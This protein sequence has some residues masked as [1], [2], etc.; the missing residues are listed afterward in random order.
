MLRTRPAGP[1]TEGT[2]LQSQGARHLRL[3]ALAEVSFV[4]LKCGVEDD[5]Y[6]SRQALGTCRERLHDLALM[7]LSC[8]VIGAGAA[9]SSAATG[10]AQLGLSMML[11]EKNQLGG[12]CLFSEFTKHAAG[13]WYKPALFGQRPRFLATVLQKRPGLQLRGVASLRDVSLWWRRTPG[14]AKRLPSP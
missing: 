1:S 6:I 3:A 7:P 4:S 13:Q 5:R 14:F 11:V 8:D 2:A 12:D 9:G 10:T